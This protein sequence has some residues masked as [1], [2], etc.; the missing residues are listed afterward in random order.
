L[1]STDSILSAVAAGLLT[2][3]GVVAGVFLD[4]YFK[5]EARKEEKAERVVLLA[6]RTAGVLHH[7][8]HYIGLN[9]AKLEPILSK[10]L[11]GKS[12]TAS[13]YRRIVEDALSTFPL[14]DLE[15]IPFPEQDSEGYVL[16]AVSDLIREYVREANE[17]AE[18]LKAGKRDVA[19]VSQFVVAAERAVD[20]DVI[21]EVARKEFSVYLDSLELI[22]GR[23]LKKKEK[24]DA[25][26][27]FRSDLELSYQA[28]VLLGDKATE[29]RKFVEGYLKK[30]GWD[31]SETL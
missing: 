17:A 23:E 4:R 12:P 8:I 11:E 10:N 14:P 27:K 13:E 29:F 26:A 30:V 3:L 31:E 9:H 19:S 7:L 24:E 16:V 21:L 18:P 15:R 5:S 1:S 6:H 28:A 25:T 2:L 22:H 20:T